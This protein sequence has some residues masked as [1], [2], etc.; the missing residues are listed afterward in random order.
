MPTGEGRLYLAVVL[1]LWSRCVVG[2]SM[3]DHLRA[4]L[5]GA[6][7][8]MAVLK[9]RPAAGLLHHSDRGVQ[10]ACADY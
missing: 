8:R 6:A 2:G 5:T 7:L 10:Y 3:A 9:R 4:D 1:D